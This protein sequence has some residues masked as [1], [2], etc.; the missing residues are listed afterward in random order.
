MSQIPSWLSA[1]KLTLQQWALV[2]AA[3]A[4]GGLALLVVYYKR[5]LTRTKIN[6]LSQHFENEQQRFDQSFAAA[7]SK[8]ERSKRNYEDALSRYHNDSVN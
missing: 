4:I 2:T 6:L 3:A 1:A 5:E 8:V 7:A